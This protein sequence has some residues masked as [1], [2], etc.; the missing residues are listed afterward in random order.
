MMFKSLGSAFTAWQFL[1]DR[2]LPAMVTGASLRNWLDQ[3][4]DQ[5]H[6]L[7]VLAGCMLRTHIGPSLAPAIAHRDC[8]CQLGEGAYMVDP[9]PAV[10]GTS[11]TV[12]PQL[13]TSLLVG[14]H[15]S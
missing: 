11:N 8:G 7:A 6:A 13:P 1:E 2:E 3:M 14:A 15:Q 10:V 5:L 9:T 12:R 4:S